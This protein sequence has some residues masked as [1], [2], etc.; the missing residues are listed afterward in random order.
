MSEPAQETPAGRQ[1]QSG[2]IGRGPGRLLLS[3]YG[4]FTVA[5]VSRSLVQM[6]TKFH[7]APLAYV[8]SAAAG[9]VYA[10]ITVALWRGGEAARKVAL[11]CCS[12]E[13]AGVIA[14]GAFTLIDPSAFPDATVWSDFGIG[15]LFLP[16][17]LPV[18]GLLWLRRSAQPQQP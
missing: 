8:L 5:A 18:A 10:V 7:D 2:R 11:V 9:L 14:V 15:Y 1:E 6:I 12:A 16:L 17:L 13:L 3:L 4:V